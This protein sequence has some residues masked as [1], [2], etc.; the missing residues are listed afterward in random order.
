METIT[1]EKNREIKSKKSLL[2]KINSHIQTVTVPIS[3]V[4]DEFE[5]KLIPN[6]QTLHFLVMPMYYTY[7]ITYFGGEGCGGT[8][9]TYT[10]TAF[11]IS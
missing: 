11:Y 6:T 5:S 8:G 4:F 9:E 7:C 10:S 3:F 1:T 2:I